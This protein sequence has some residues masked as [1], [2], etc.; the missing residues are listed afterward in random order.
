MKNAPIFFAAMLLCLFSCN[1][2]QPVDLIL[3]NGVVYTVDSAFTIAGAF[4]VKDGKI[5]DVGT[6]EE[7][8]G[9]YKSDSVIDAGGKAV[10]PGF[11]DAHCHF[12]GYGT[13]LT[14]VDLVGCS[15]E[16]EMISRVE[17]WAAKNPDGWILG[18]GWDQNDWPGKTFPD[19]TELDRLFPERPVYLTRVDGHA[20]LVN[21]AAMK[22]AGISSATK[23]SGG[24]VELK[25]GFP[26]GILIDNAM[27]LV[28]AKIP[29]PSDK[30]SEEALLKAQQNCF[31]VGLTTV[32]DAGLPLRIVKLIEKMQEAGTL[33]MRIYAML[34]PT[35]ENFQAFRK[36]LI[37]DRLSVRSFKIYADGALGS[38]GAWLL[39]PYA[40]DPGNCGLLLQDSAYYHL[41][42][43]RCKENGFQLNVHAIGDAANQLMLSVFALY[44][45]RNMDLRWRIEHAQVV[46]ETDFDVFGNYG[47][48]PSVQ[49]T[50]ATSDMS[51][52]GDR[53]GSRIKNA[54]AYRRLMRQNGWIPLGTDFPVENIN[55]M[56]TLFAAVARQNEDCMPEGG[57]QITDELSR[58]EALRGMTI[59]A[60]MANF[61]EKQKGSIEVGKVADFVILD[62]DIVKCPIREARDAKVLRTVLNGET[63]FE[64]ESL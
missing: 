32:D 50:H 8:L 45:E 33:K 24:V 37:Q 61:E 34:D 27:D 39:E 60:A 54:Y 28:Y 46:A 23:I 13:N 47:I 62:R 38:R 26:S 63:V 3:H 2:K 22:M 30:Q 53:L 9:K 16:N 20:A 4:A 14:K 57:F 59:W 51:W 55:P 31:A 19:K 6:N 1:N 58:K 15:S 49:P 42:A 52:A 64:V 7:I 5:I 44:N 35:E 56:F 29:Q 12:F 40:D 11:I 17:D 43:K 18:R 41:W 25:G 36:P 10:Y 48:I 21:S